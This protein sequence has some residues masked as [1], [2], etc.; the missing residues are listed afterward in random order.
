MRKRAQLDVRPVPDRRSRNGAQ[1]GGHDTWSHRRD[2]NRRRLAH[3]GALA[4]RAELADFLDQVAPEARRGGDFTIGGR[5]RDVV[6]GAERQRSQAHLRVAA[7]EGGRH[8]DDQVALLLKQQRQRFDAVEF[9]HLDVEQN[10]IRIVPQQLVDR[11]AAGAQRRDDLEVGLRVDP[12]RDQPAHHDRVIDDHDAKRVRCRNRRG[13]R[14]G[15]GDAHTRYSV[16]RTLQ[17]RRRRTAEAVQIS[18]TSWNL[19]STISLSNGF[20]MY[21]FAPALSAR[22]MCATSFSVVQNTT[23]G[24]SPP[25]RRRIALRKS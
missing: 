22:A 16:T 5:L 24:T 14:N 3:K 21:S 2:W 20:M 17:I 19:A 15:G 12:A 6:G 8:D 7:R 18:P 23:L 13:G 11:L 9:G 10:D 4:P 1:W 25:G